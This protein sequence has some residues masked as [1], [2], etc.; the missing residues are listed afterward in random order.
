M[1]TVSMGNSGIILPADRVSY[2]NA[3]SGLEAEIVQ[4]AIDELNYEASTSVTAFGG[5]LA[6]FTRRG[7][8]CAVSFTGNPTESATITQWTTLVNIPEGFRPK[9]QCTGYAIDVQTSPYKM[10]WL[11]AWPPDEQGL[12]SI[13]ALNGNWNHATGQ[14][15]ILKLRGTMIYIC[16]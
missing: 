9:I 10:A 2:D 7:N 6:T 1:P 3:T 8:L 13:I 12:N 15:L 5:L 16:E 14:S 11:G 4:D